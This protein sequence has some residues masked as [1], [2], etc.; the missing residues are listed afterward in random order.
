MHRKLD[1]AL[2]FQEINL[3]CNSMVRKRNL[4]LLQTLEYNVAWHDIMLHHITS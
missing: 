4:V 3:T 1:N 2:D